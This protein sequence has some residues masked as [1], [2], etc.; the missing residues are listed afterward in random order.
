MSIVRH[1]HMDAKDGEAGKVWFVWWSSKTCNGNWV[2]SHS[3]DW[4]ADY[5]TS[6]YLWDVKTGISKDIWIASFILLAIE[7]YVHDRFLGCSQERQKLIG[8][9]LTA[10]FVTREVKHFFTAPMQQK[11][12]CCKL[13]GKGNKNFARHWK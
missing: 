2:I 13:G 10:T 6:A 8:L 5:K 7:R 12:F 3:M 9:N 1:W 11:K 4:W